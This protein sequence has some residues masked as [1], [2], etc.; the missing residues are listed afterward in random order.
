MQSLAW[1]KYIVYKLGCH[2]W[3]ILFC[4]KDYDKELDDCPHMEIQFHAIFPF[5]THWHSGSRNIVF[6]QLQRAT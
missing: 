3:S 4:V 5:T 2:G 1:R 6:K